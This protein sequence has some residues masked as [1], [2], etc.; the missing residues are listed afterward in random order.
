[1]ACALP[2]P[3][4]TPRLKYNTPLGGQCGLRTVVF[5]HEG[6]G[7]VGSTGNRQPPKAHLQLT[8]DTAHGA[9]GQGIILQTGTE[10][11]VWE[12]DKGPVMVILDHQLD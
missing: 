3:G 8:E 11:Q 7:S 4:Q 6:E 9:C 2:A 10:E 12:H 1:M 5:V